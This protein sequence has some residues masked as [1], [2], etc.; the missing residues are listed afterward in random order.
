MDAQLLQVLTHLDQTLTQISH[1]LGWF[2]TLNIGITLTGGLVL[3]S[4]LWA[5]RRQMAREADLH[6]KAFS[7]ITAIAQSIASQTRELLRRTDP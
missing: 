3:V 1:D 4:L 7:D 5:M 2:F 6:A